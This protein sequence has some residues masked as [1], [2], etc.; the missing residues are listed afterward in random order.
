MGLFDPPAITLRKRVPLDIVSDFNSV[1]ELALNRLQFEP[2]E[3]KPY[4]LGIV[5]ALWLKAG[6]LSGAVRFAPGD[7][8]K[9]QAVYDSCLRVLKSDSWTAFGI[10]IELA[11][12]DCTFGS[13]PELYEQIRMELAGW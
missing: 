1:E 13:P 6:E 5:L 9:I 7:S 4:L 10:L 12:A 2:E 8:R 11:N 3:Q